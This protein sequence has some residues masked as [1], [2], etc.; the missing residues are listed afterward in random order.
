MHRQIYQKFILHLSLFGI[1]I[2]ILVGFYDVIFGYL[3]EFIHI[4]LEIIEISLDRLVE[5]LF[6]TDLHDTQM[7]V[8]YIMLV[9]GG[10]LLYLVWKTLV[11]MY[12]GII[13][14]SFN[15]WKEL[16][17]AVTSDWQSMTMTNRVIC[18]SLFLLVNYLAS[19]LLF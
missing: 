11:Y 18:I 16:K 12:R 14:N 3:W 15:E 4:I 2:S 17:A 19:F 7:I 10:I 6:E 13:Q 9:V 5:H 8:F 1:A